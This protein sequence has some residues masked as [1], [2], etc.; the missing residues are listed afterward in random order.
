MTP[1]D[2]GRQARKSGRTL[3][4]V[5]AAYHWSTN[6]YDD[7]MTGWEDENRRSRTQAPCD[8]LIEMVEALDDTL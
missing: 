2:K 8:P 6:E 7:W 5:P 3:G 4:S 1:Y